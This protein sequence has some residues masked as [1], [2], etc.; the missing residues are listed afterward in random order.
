MR[1]LLLLLQF[2][3]YTIFLEKKI[4]KNFAV[5]VTVISRV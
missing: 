4:N 5:I 2:S 1:I 3:E